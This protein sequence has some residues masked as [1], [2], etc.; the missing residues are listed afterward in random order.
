MSQFILMFLILSNIIYIHSE[1]TLTFEYMAEKVMK[2]GKRKKIAIAGGDNLTM[3]QC[4]RIAK[5]I[6][7][8]DCILIGDAAKTKQI[9]KEENIDISDFELIDIKE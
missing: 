2:L 7:I 6:G 1:N 5:S 8:A 4:C 9:A 3:L